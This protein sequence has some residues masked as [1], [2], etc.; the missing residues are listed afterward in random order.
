MEFGI[1]DRRQPIEGLAVAVAPGA[2][3]PAYIF[4]GRLF[5]R[6]VVRLNRLLLSSCSKF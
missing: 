5:S 6:I 1:D 3:Q 4:E 2:K